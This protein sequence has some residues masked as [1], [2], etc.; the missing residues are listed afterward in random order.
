M[1]GQDRNDP[2]AQQESLRGDVARLQ[3]VLP[4]EPAPV[5]RPILVVV[6]GLP[7][8]GKSSFSRELAAR[9]PL[10]VLESDA[11]RRALVPRPRYSAEESA[12]L[13]RAIHHLMAGLL[14]RKTPTLLD[15]TNL[16][17]AQRE[18]LYRMAQGAGAKLLLVRVRAPQEVVRA[19]LT[20]RQATADPHERSDAGWEVYQRMRDTYEPI[21]REHYTVDTS[22]NVEPVLRRIVEELEGWVRMH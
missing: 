11:L 7:G 2:S 4:P 1:S 19:R 17:E 16:V 14:A 13:F 10:L 20:S 6:A 21:R 12:R 18:P 3:A 15:A 9:F 5:P 22:R 8:T